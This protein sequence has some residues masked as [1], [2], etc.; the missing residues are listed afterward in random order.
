M[1]VD[2]ALCE[3]GE[4]PKECD[5]CALYA[6]QFKVSKLRDEVTALRAKLARIAAALRGES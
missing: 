2:E 3:H 4:Q 5:K 1:T 6:E